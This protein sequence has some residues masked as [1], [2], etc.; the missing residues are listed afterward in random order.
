M[1][2]ARDSGIE[3]VVLVLADSK[4]NRALLHSEGDRLRASFPL[5]G[6]AARAAI[7]SGVDPGCNV[8]ILV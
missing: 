5:Q 1:L 4:R 8:L 7:T 2:K 6:R 3:R